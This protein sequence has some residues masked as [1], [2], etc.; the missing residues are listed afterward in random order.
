MGTFTESSSV[1]ILI[2]RLVLS[3]LT[4]KALNQIALQSHSQV[5][6]LL[7]IFARIWRLSVLTLMNIFDDFFAVCSISTALTTFMLLQQS[8]LQRTLSLVSLRENISFLEKKTFNVFTRTIKIKQTRNNIN[9]LNLYT[10]LSTQTQSQ[11]KRTERLKQKPEE[12]KVNE[13]VDHEREREGS[14]FVGHS[15]DYHAYNSTMIVDRAY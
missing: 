2:G 4:Y 7:N 5:S 10:P 6:T 8:T 11:I 3:S 12:I 14:W 9:L 15:S 13:T 1:S